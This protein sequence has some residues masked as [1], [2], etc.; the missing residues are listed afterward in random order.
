[1]KYNLSVLITREDDM[2]VARCAEL[3]VTSQGGTLDEAK[4]NLK[5]AVELYIESF[6]ADD[7]KDIKGEPVFTTIEVAA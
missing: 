6:G 1:M 5:E 3:D 4:T 7:I 2:F